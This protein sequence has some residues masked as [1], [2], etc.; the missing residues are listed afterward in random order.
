MLFIW[1]N[2][3]WKVSVRVREWN[4][5]MKHAL[6]VS[7]ALRHTAKLWWEVR[8]REDECSIWF[9]FGRFLYDGRKVFWAIINPKSE[10]TNEEKKLNCHGFLQKPNRFFQPVLAERVR[11]NA[12]K[13]FIDDAPVLTEHRHDSSK[14]QRLEA[15]LQAWSRVG[16]K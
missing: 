6:H 5:E 7:H 1:S 11:E 12:V 9:P 16:K 14:Q 15:L 3:M 4:T 10:T 2:Q 8:G 13:I